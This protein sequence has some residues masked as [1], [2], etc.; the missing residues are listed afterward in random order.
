MPATASACNLQLRRRID[1]QYTT[2]PFDGWPR[3]TAHWR[4]LGLPVNHNRVQRLMRSLGLQA[5]Y[6]KPR[7]SST[8]RGHKL[9]PYL[10]GAV[11]VNRST[12]VWR[13]NITS[14]RMAKGCMYLV[15][16]LE[17]W[18]RS[19]LAWQLSKTLDVPFCLVALESALVHGRPE[20]F[21][22]DQGLQFTSDAFPSR[23][24]RAGIAISMDGRGRALDNI[25]VERLWRTVKDEEMYLK[26]DATVP[27]LEAGLAHYF[28][29]YSDDRPHHSLGDRTPAEVHREP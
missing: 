13:A 16:I 2:T 24:E 9:D 27:A 17:W 4:R 10:L 29:F 15:A 23:L 25:C 26:D 22:T 18:S 6:P 14:V 28:T 11:V 20:I 21:N 8:A 7:P 1:E 19:V 5:S 3:L 12:Q